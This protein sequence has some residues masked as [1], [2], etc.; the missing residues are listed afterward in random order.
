MKIS[1][2][3]INRETFWY[4]GS[5]NGNL[6]DIHR[7]S[8]EH[9]FFVT[10]SLNYA[11][12]YMALDTANGDKPVSKKNGKFV[13]CELSKNIKIFDLTS[14]EDYTQLHLPNVL[15]MLFSKKVNAW[16]AFWYLVGS[17]LK[18]DMS[19]DSKQLDVIASNMMRRI[20]ELRKFKIN[21]NDVKELKEW[22]QMKIDKRYWYAFDLNDD[23]LDRN[24]QYKIIAQ[25]FFNDIV[26]LGYDSC[27]NDEDGA[28]AIAIFNIAAINRISAKFLTYEEVV[29]KFKLKN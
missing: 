20:I 2:N 24:V 3:Y 14:E 26:D 19:L 13:V 7:P 22:L 23:N 21:A 9:P 4:H 18:L 15:Q 1:E 10:S 16:A 6:N 11:L 25:M 29:E 12:E 5:A 28:I 27:M 17:H 8:A